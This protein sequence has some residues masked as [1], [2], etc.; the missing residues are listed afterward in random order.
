MKPK[1]DVWEL[2]NIAQLDYEAAQ[3][4]KRDKLN[5]RLQ[6]W[7]L[8]IGLVAGFGLVSSQSSS[9]SYVVALYPLLAACIARYAG[10]SEE[11]LDQIKAY[12]LQVEAENGFGGYEGFNYYRKRRGSG[13]HKKALRDALVVT[14]AL[15]I[16][17]VVVRLVI[18]AL[19]VV[20]VLVVAGELVAVGMTIYFLRHK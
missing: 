9:I 1:K 10:H 15:A 8:F 16:G 6:L 17:V 18:D 7:S 14:E 3:A 12:L 4:E 11:V 2:S 13:G 19:P 20:A 5:A